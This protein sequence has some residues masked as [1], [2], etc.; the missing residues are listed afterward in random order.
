MLVTWVPKKEAHH[1]DD[2]R[3]QASV[4]WADRPPPPRYQVTAKAEPVPPEC[5]NR[6]RTALIPLESEAGRPGGSSG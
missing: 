2:G 6:S 1:D 4:C 5:G 3:T